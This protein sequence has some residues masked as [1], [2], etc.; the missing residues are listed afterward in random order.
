M[1]SREL[2]TLVAHPEELGIQECVF[3][4]FASDIRFRFKMSISGV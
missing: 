1:M 3:Q 2:I 4:P